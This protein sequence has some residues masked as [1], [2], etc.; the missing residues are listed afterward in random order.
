MNLILANMLWAETV[1][2]AMKVLCE[3]LNC[4]NVASDGAL[5]VVTTLELVQHQLSESGH[6]SLLVTQ[7]LHGRKRWGRPRGS[8]RRA[9]GLVQTPIEQEIVLHSPPVYDSITICARRRGIV[10]EGREELVGQQ[11]GQLSEFVLTL[12]VYY[13]IG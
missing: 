6:S 9:S 12:Y 2:R 3:V 1:W 4:V 13:S 8:V 5:G 7:T 11:V 10:P